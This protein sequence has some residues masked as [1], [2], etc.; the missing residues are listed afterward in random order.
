V[1]NKI[2]ELFGGHSNLAPPA[3]QI[4][5]YSKFQLWFGVAVALISGTGQFFWWKKM[6]KGKLKKELV[7]P[8]LVSLIVFAIIISI[9]K[10]T[11]PFTSC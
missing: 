8:I 1:Y 9:A 10:S 11:I 2:V 4:A 3:N 7:T 5:F 6:D